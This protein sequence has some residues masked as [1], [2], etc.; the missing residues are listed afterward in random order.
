[1][2]RDRA[3]FERWQATITVSDIDSVLAAAIDTWTSLVVD[4]ILFANITIVFTDLAD[5]K[6]TEVDGTTI[7]IDINAAGWGWFIDPI[8][9]DSDEYLTVG[10]DRIALDNTDA[11]NKIDLLTV[12]IHELGH[13]LSL[14][15]DHSSTVVQ[16][17]LDISVRRLPSQRF[18]AGVSLTQR[19]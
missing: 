11:D 8:P 16:D 6:L 7:Y 18:G 9:T 14:E 13:I 5:L 1:M 19:P 4:P 12:L 17:T 15:H 2:S 3:H 10:R